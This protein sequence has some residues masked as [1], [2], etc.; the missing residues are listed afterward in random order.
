M[1]TITLRSANRQLSSDLMLSTPNAC[2]DVVYV[3]GRVT[4]RDGG[5]LQSLGD[6]MNVGRSKAIM[7]MGG[8][9]SRNDQSKQDRGHE[10]HETKEPHDE[11]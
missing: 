1:L 7:M 3:N 4:I 11:R 2:I 5:N 10:S 9:Q 6:S 8:A